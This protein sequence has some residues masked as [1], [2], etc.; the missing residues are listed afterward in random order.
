MSTKKYIIYFIFM[1][2]PMFAIS[3]L[4]NLVYS[5]N[6]HDYIQINWL[7]VI[8]LALVLAAFFTRMHTRKDNE[9]K[10]E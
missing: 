6:T 7:I 5:L 3:V 4:L 1:F 2:F 9:N 10:S 8:L